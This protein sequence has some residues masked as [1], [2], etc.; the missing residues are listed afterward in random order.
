[1]DLSFFCCLDLGVCLQ[2]SFHLKMNENKA[3]SRKVK[4]GKSDVFPPL[5]PLAELVLA[6]VVLSY[7]M[8][9]TLLMT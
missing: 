3:Q 4:Y 5:A 2:H 6:V 1:M 7:N 8:E 9:Y